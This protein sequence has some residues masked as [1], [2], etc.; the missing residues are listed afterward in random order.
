MSMSRKHYKF[1]AQ[2]LRE[3]EMSNDAR[4]NIV[5]A[6]SIVFKEDNPNFSGVRFLQAVSGHKEAL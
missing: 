6:L 1:I 2:T 3:T 5:A 4:A